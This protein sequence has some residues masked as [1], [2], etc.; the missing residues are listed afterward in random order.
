MALGFIDKL[1][2]E[3]KKHGALVRVTIVDKRGSAPR[4]VGASMFVVIN[5]ISGTVG[6]GSLEYEA[7]LQARKLLAETIRSGQLWSRELKEYPLGPALGQCCGGS[8]KLLLEVF[9]KLEFKQLNP[10]LETVDESPSLFF[11]SM[12]SGTPLYF[13]NHLRDVESGSLTLNRVIGEIIGGIRPNKP[14]FVAEPKSAS[15]WF[16]EPQRPSTVPLYLYGGGHVGREIA[17]VVEGLPFDLHWVDFAKERFPETTTEF[18]KIIVTSEPQKLA[19]DSKDGAFHLVMTHSHPVDL[20]ICHS[21]LKENKFGFLGLIGSETKRARFIKRFR[22]SG[23]SEEVIERMICPIGIDIGGG[24]NPAI[25]AV[26][27]AAQIIKELE[28]SLKNNKTPG[29]LVETAPHD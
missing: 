14:C 8:V 24:R 15:G 22:E 3:L 29:Q 11:R 5:H 16:I 9:T 6:G 1:S 21:V 27:V 12:M 18:A 25:I 7:I 13:V 4:E 23:I 26:S 10:I 28:Q 20:A 19:A 17:R 2:D